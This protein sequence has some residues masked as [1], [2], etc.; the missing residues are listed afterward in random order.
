MPRPS[1]SL[2]IAELKRTLREQG[3][4]YARIAR[5]LKL[6]LPTIKRMF[7]REDFT[8]QRFERICDLAGCTLADIAAR[9][10]E[11]GAPLRQLTVAQEQ[12]IVGDPKLLLVTWLVIN[13]MP[14]EEIVR[15]YRLT[16]REVLAQLIRLDRLKVIELQP[17]NRVRLLISRHFSWRP[18]GPV[19]SYIHERMLKD[20]LASHFSGPDEEFWFHGSKVSEAS[21]AALKRALRAAARECALIVDGE[22]APVA[23]RRGAAF[24]LALRRWGYSGFAPLLRRSEDS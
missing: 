1:R 24:V 12:Q 23:E 21:M 19:Q 17:G 4:T 6:S 9:S 16:E 2:L 11:R 8:L 15:T 14:F 18:G 3:L 22:R 13:K 10:H 5:A 20:F 7:S